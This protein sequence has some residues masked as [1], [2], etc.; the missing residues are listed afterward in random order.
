MKWLFGFLLLAAS[1]GGVSLAQNL[2]VS[3]PPAWWVNG[4][5]YSYHFDRSKNLAD[6]NPGLGI[7]Y[8]FSPTA[9]LT[10]GQFHNSNRT[11]SHYAGMYWQPWSWHAVKMGVV[12]GFFDGYP[13]MLQGGWFPAVIPVATVEGRRFGINLALVPPYQD[14][15]YG[16][17]SFQLK[18]RL[19]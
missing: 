3:P 8:R 18:L 5:F 19:D 11:A 17:L 2:P 16:A 7:E 13:H 9:S 1:D 15:L 12:A 6:A 10:L 4:G 14:R